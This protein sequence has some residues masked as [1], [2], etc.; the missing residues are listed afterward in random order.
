MMI[1]RACL[2]AS[3]FANFAEA[4]AIC[5]LVMVKLLCDDGVRKVRGWM[6]FRATRSDEY[7]KRPLATEMNP[8]QPCLRAP[9]T[10]RIP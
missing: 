10:P 5:V 6:K 9:K 8:P 2:T 4:G 1:V 7:Q 3:A